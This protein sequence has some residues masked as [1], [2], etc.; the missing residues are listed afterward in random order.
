MIYL[1]K[2]RIW[3]RENKSVIAYTFE[4]KNHK[5]LAGM[6]LENEE[7]RRAFEGGE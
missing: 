4:D 6:F 2:W 3:L 1:H 5:P 7:L